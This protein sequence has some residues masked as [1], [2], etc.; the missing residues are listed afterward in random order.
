[1]SAAEVYEWGSE[2]DPG[3]AVY[4][5][6]GAHVGP[7]VELTAYSVEASPLEL[8]IFRGYIWDDLSEGEC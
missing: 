1:M 8:L 4:A 6:E 3:A 2:N 5:A 7:G